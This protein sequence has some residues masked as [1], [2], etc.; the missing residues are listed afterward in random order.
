M[1]KFH[2]A[3]C[4]GKISIISQ[5]DL[6]MEELL[7]WIQRFNVSAALVNEETKD[8]RFQIKLLRCPKEYLVQ[9][10]DQL[11]CGCS[12]DHFFYPEIAK[13]VSQILELYYERQQQYQ[14][15]ASCV[16]HKKTNRCIVFVG[17]YWQGKS[18]C[19]FS[20]ANLS[21]DYMLV[22]DNGILVKGN[23]I[24]DAVRFFSLNARNPLNRQFDSY[25]VIKKRNGRCYYEIE[26]EVVP[27]PLKICA[28]LVP[29][30]NST[31][32]NIHIV[33]YEEAIWF[34]YQKFS[35]L[36]AGETILMNGKMPSPVYDND[37]L[38]MAR[39][40]EVRNL[41]DRIPLLYAY[42]PLD[43]IRTIAAQRLEERK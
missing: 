19:A 37:Q 24:V 6:D 26:R 28:I 11:I 29:H 23:S 15:H 1:R 17:D 33:P 35:N 2:V 32:K 43:T 27:F 30:I 14:L 22:S 38:R 36:I 5:I 8:Y 4:V 10:E 31:G 20:L 12:W 13:L 7:F 16:M 3:T 40:N 41:L 42:A 39:L 34:L 21:P 9:L 18:S 25:S